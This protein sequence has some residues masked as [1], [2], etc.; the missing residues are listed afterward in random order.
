[1]SED[2]AKDVAVEL[3]ESALTTAVATATGEIPSDK[4]SEI[5]KN[6]ENMKQLGSL[7]ANVTNS[8]PPELRGEI[9]KLFEA[10]TTGDQNQ[11]FANAL[12]ALHAKLIEIYN[13]SK[14]PA[15]GRKR[16]RTK[17]RKNY[18]KRRT[19]KRR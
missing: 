15:G 17:K 9:N 5:L 10:R 4:L 19:T 13:S 3:A 14:V 11:E 6:E 8:V 16:R 1:M 12:K 18:K 7:I 2:V